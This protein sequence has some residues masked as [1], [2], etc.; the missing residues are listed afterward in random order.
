MISRKTV[1]TLLASAVAL[2]IAG[3][4]TTANAMPEGHE[5]CFGV[6]KAGM[7]DCAAMD[8]SHSC[9]GQA[10]ADGSAQEWVAVPAGL[11]AKLVN[12]KVAE[13]DASHDD[14]THGEKAAH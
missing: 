5:K 13:G 14:S 2:T 1:N 3:A 4:A 7:N 8:K 6:V 12:G 10:S 9:A 11:C